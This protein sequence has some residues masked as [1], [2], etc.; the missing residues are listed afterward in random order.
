MRG[1]V[2]YQTSQLVKVIFVE[3]AKKKDRIDPDHL[4]YKCIASYNTMDTYRKVWNN[5]FNYLLEHWKLKNCELITGEHVEAYFEY[6]IEYYPSK[7]YAEK[8]NS[9]LGKL[10]TALNKYSQL[11]YKDTNKEPITYDFKIRQT[12]LDNVRD[13]KLVAKNYTNRVYQS[14]QTIIDNLSSFEH[15]I[16]ASIQ[17]LGGARSEGVTF[18]KYDQLKGYKVDKISNK[19]VGVVETK[20]KGGKVGDVY[21]SAELYK[22][23]EKYFELNNTK[24]FRISYHKYAYDIRQACISLNIEPKGSHGFR[25]TFA[26][27][28]VREYQKYD[29]SYE[30]ALQGVSWEMKHFRANITEYYLGN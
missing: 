15:K 29:Y 5:L 24:T 13:L 26:Q 2:Y 22:E 4:H 12:V 27:N 17:L 3:G 25:W 16:A 18:I 10:E 7:Q 23:L 6:K 21:I 19:E 1:S 28:R 30:Q 14:P 11:K 9:A 8:L 20:E